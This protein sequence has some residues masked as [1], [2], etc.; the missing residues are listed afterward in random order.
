MEEEEEFSF[1]PLSSPLNK[2]GTGSCFENTFS[3]CQS[4]RDCS[5]GRCTDAWCLLWEKRFRFHISCSSEAVGAAHGL[6][7]EPSPRSCY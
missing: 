5:E 1:L 7:A 6:Y 2:R 4:S 3:D